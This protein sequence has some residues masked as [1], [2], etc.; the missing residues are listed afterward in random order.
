[1][2]IKY[3]KFC[4]SDRLEIKEKEADHDL[5][6]DAFMKIISKYKTEEQ[7][8]EFI[9]EYL[10]SNGEYESTEKCEQCGDYDTIIN[11]EI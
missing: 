5:I 9:I 6:N 7:K 4:Y 11:M 1:M 3:S 10:R 2:K 8:K